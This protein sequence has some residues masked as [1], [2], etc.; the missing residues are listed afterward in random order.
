MVEYRV[1][2]TA[3]MERKLT[4]LGKDGIAPLVQGTD[5]CR[6]VG[7]GAADENIWGDG[8]GHGHGTTGEHIND[9]GETHYGG[10]KF[11]S[12]EAENKGWGVERSGMPSRRT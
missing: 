9:S 3:Q 12:W 7:I 11:G 4:E 10:E 1:D 5:H 8:G 2:L 6:N